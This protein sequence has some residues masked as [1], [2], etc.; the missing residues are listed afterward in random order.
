[1]PRPLSTDENATTKLIVDITGAFKRRINRMAAF[2]G[3]YANEYVRR[4]V[5]RA[6]A[7]DEEVFKPVIERLEQTPE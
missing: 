2:H 6:I 5:E 3:V 1:M 7:D 4:A